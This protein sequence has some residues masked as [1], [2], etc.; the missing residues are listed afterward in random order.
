[1]IAIELRGWDR[2]AARQ[3]CSNHSDRWERISTNM[4][5]SQTYPLYSSTSSN[6]NLQF[7]CS[8]QIYCYFL[9][10]LSL[11]NAPRILSLWFSI[12]KITLF[13]YSS[14][15]CF[16]NV[17]FGIVSISLFS[18]TSV[19]VEVNY[20]FLKCQYTFQLLPTYIA[21]D[22]IHSACWNYSFEVDFQSGKWTSCSTGFSG[23]IR[24]LRFTHHDL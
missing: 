5:V 22:S 9:Y 11:H 24:N 7:L 12:L 3:H 1:M 4:L 17:Y 20:R 10:R 19:I 23:N 18:S 15:D 16:P 8:I 21:A 6:S 14:F 2:L 13:W